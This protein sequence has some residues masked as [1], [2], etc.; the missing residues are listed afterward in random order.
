MSFNHALFDRIPAF[1]LAVCLLTVSS[2]GFSPKDYCE[3]LPIDNALVTIDTSFGPVVIELFHDAAPK[4][5]SELIARTSDKN[6]KSN[7]FSKQVFNY[8]LPNVEIRTSSST[9]DDILSNTELDAQALGLHEQTIDNASEAM[10]L[11]QEEI[12]PMHHRYREGI[13]LTPQLTKWL[14]AWYKTYRADFLVGVSKQQINEALGYKYTAALNS[15]RPV[16][17]S[18]MLVPHSKT[19]ASPALSIALQD[20]PQRTGKWM[21]VGRVV[22]GM[23]VAHTISLSPLQQPRNIKP[24]GY[25][26]K[27]PVVINSMTRDCH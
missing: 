22:D 4:A 2:C 16:R 9:P 23:D 3:N 17:G 11:M 25:R 26:P 21:V 15:R 7:Y 27:T 8:T 20:F 5:V 13:S 1:T 24:E 10:S 12:L 18:V 19:Q 6:V 14:K